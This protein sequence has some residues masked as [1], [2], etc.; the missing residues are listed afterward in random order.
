MLNASVMD[1]AD[2]SREGELDTERSASFL[3]A[4]IRRVCRSAAS[5]W[6]GVC[7]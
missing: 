4:I 6:G 5:G 1:A 7:R 2:S 3:M